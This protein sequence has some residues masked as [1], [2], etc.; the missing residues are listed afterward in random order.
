MSRAGRPLPPSP[1]MTSACSTICMKPPAGLMI[2]SPPSSASSP[3]TTRTGARFIQCR[4]PI[5]ILTGG[6]DMT[7]SRTKFYLDKQRSEEHTSELQ[8]LMRISYAVLC[9][10]KKKQQQKNINRNKSNKENMNKHNIEIYGK[11]YDK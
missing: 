11:K 4:S 9:L 1:Q 10:K 2:A 6:T 3:R 5:M 8:S 7:A